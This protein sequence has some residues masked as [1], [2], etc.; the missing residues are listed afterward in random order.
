MGNSQMVKLVA[1]NSKRWLCDW[2]LENPPLP[3]H[4][5]M[6]WVTG[7]L[8]LITVIWMDPRSF[9]KLF[10]TKYCFLILGDDTSFF[11]FLLSFFT[12]VGKTYFLLLL[13]LL[14]LLLNELFFHKNILV[15]SFSGM[16][17][18]VPECSMF[19]VLSTAV[20]TNIAQFLQTSIKRT[21]SIKRTLGKVPK[22]CA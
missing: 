5:N 13:L 8:S 10:A 4:F 17:G 6:F 12:N 1:N 22:E 15:F 21:P 9:N 18:N 2:K 7:K 20:L 16:F 11:F 19:L 3:T 14:L